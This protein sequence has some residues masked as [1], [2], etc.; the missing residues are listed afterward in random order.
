MDIVAR[1]WKDEGP[2][3]IGY[4]V[5]ILRDVALAEELAQDALEAA[6][7]EWPRSGVPERPGA[8]LVTT[9]RN[10]ALN[11]LRRAKV[12]TRTGEQLAH[13]TPVAGDFDMPETIPDD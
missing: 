3:V 12:A 2:R 13:E 7:E 11:T 1:V 9:A 8:W 6:L 10:R 4:L 5:R